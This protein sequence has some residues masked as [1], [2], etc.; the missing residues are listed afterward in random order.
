MKGFDDRMIV[1]T[2]YS[3]H[4]TKLYEVD[5]SILGVTKEQAEMF[6]ITLAE[7]DFPGA[8]GSTTYEIALGAWTLQS[9]YSPDNYRQAIDRNN[10]V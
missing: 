10:F 5:T 2:S 4:Y 8:G 7:G 9:F 6:N 3:I 1:I